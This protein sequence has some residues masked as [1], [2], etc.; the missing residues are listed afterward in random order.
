MQEPLSVDDL[1]WAGGREVPSTQELAERRAAAE[2]ARWPVDSRDATAGRSDE[3]LAAE[4]DALAAAPAPPGA[5]AGESVFGA[6]ADP[7]AVA[8]D[9][10]AAAAA[11]RSAQ[12]LVRPALVA[13]PAAPAATAGQSRQAAEAARWLDAFD[14]KREQG[15]TRGA[16][17]DARIQAYDDAWR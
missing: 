13:V 5:C 1:R 10:A 15:E 12:A 14:V 9:E 7:A 6:A 3:E 16:K 8:A 17:L 2:A 11:P 4:A